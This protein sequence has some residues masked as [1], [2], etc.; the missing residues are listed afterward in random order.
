MRVRFPDDLPYAIDLDRSARCAVVHI[1]GP[2]DMTTSLILRIVL[3][4]LWDAVDEGCLILDL[5]AMTFCDS[6]G[7][8]AL[9]EAFKESREHGTQILLAAASSSLLRMLHTMGLIALFETHST[10]EEALAASERA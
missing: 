8:A 3:E 10:L 5:T 1:T 7:V 2:L 4:P 6:T 9:I